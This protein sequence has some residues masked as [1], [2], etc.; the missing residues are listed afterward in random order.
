M[1]GGTNQV[2]VS[3]FN[4]DGSQADANLLLIYSSQ[5]IPD[6]NNPPISYIGTVTDISDSVI[7]IKDVNGNI[8]QIKATTDAHFIDTRASLNKEIKSTDLQLE[9]T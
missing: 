9:I 4:T 5:Y 8:E 1:A 2:L 6:P 7:Q 3:A